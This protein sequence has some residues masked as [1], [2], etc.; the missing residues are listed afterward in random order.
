MTSAIR[1]L[2]RS[3]I[4]YPDS[5]GLPMADHTLQCRCM[6]TFFGGIEAIYLDDPNVF[7]ACN[8]LWYPVQGEPTIRL[9]PDVLV[10]FGRPKGDRGSYMQWKEDDVP[11][12]VVF[13]I[14]APGNRPGE[15]RRKRLFYEQYGVEEYYTYDPDDGALEG[16]RRVRNRLSKIRKMAGFVSPRLGIRFDPGTGPDSLRIIGP[17]GKLF[18]TFAEL[19]QKSQRI[20]RLA[21]ALSERASAADERAE[22][23]SR[24]AL[25]ADERAEEQSRLALAADQRA[26]EQARLALAER[27]RAEEHARLA[28]AERQR[29][30]EQ[31]GFARAERQRADEQRQLA[32]EQTRLVL[33]E[34]Q[35]ADEQ[36]QLADEQRQRAD[37]E[38]RRSERLAARLRELGVEPD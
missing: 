3:A 29:A 4:E 30:D 25:A 28:L 20:E 32:E 12:Q 21:E 34:R 13:E 27:Q 19:V 6:I 33:A 5:D 35:R 26:E 38:R 7:V 24:L 10:A 16:W 2:E 23:Q 31:A 17:D 36:R 22:E 11:L 1:L 15:M 18:L 14:L 9:A 37:E 8:L